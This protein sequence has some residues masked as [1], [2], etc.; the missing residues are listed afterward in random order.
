MRDPGRTPGRI[1][2]PADLDAVTAIGEEDHTGID[3]AAVDRIWQAT[4]AAF[5]APQPGLG[6]YPGPNGWDK[7]VKQ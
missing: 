7:G 6:T 3:G 5:L 1:D 2:V 4:G